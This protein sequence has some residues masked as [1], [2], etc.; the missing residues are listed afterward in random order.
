MS[1]TW[2]TSGWCPPSVEGQPRYYWTI[3]FQPNGDAWSPQGCLIGG[4]PAGVDLEDLLTTWFRERGGPAAP[5]RIQ[6]TPLDDETAVLAEKIVTFTE[7]V[8]R[9]VK[10]LGRPQ[11]PVA[12]TFWTTTILEPP[13]PA[14]LAAWAERDATK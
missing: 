7:A 8:T 12:P 4:P 14:Q 11:G 9:P 13:S 5:W 1:A 10:R 3:S 2:T 6:V